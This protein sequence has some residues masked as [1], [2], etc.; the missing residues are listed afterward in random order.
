MAKESVFSFSPGGCCCK[1]KECNPMDRFPQII[2]YG[3]HPGEW[4]VILFG[5][6]LDCS[7]PVNYI[8]VPP[9]FNCNEQADQFW[10]IGQNYIEARS[11]TNFKWIAQNKYLIYCDKYNTVNV[12]LLMLDTSTDT[13][14][15]LIE[16]GDW[17]ILGID[18]TKNVA[19]YV[20]KSESPNHALYIIGPEEHRQTFSQL[21]PSLNG[22]WQNFSDILIDQNLEK[23]GVNTITSER[24]TG[25]FFIVNNG[26][27]IS[28]CTEEPYINGYNGEVCVAGNWRFNNNQAGA[29]YDRLY[30]RTCGGGIMKFEAVF[31]GSGIN[32][33]ESFWQCNKAKMP[34]RTFGNYDGARVFWISNITYENYFYDPSSHVCYTEYECKATWNYRT[35]EGA[36]YYVDRHTGETT[37]YRTKEIYYKDFDS[38][39]V[40]VSDDPPNTDVAGH[41][42]WPSRP[43]YITNGMV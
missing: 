33:T 24:D 40:F 32:M 19:F 9:D 3:K 16:D 5:S 26:C 39:A 23:D 41:T 15:T 28:V 12:P 30:S 4:G 37:Y 7:Y 1:N 17:R 8:L 38:T 35:F 18:T 36:T 20:K 22:A 27:N 21:D 34:K 11:T 14:T 43:C 6:P 13:L 42:A 25:P 10:Y 2:A 31:S 29:Y